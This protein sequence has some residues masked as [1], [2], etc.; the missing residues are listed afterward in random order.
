MW[1]DHRIFLQ[2]P[3]VVF[4]ALSDPNILAEEEANELENKSKIMKFQ[5]KHIL[6]YY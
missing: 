4:Q 1:A 6:D 3:L 2:D 5:L